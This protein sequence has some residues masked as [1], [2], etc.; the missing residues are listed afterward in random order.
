MSDR[1]DAPS[2][3][4]LRERVEFL[5]PS[6]ADA[7]GG[8]NTTSWLSSSPPMVRWAHVRDVGVRESFTDGQLKTMRTF[9][10]TIRFD[11]QV[12]TLVRV[13]FGSLDLQVRGVT[14][15][16]YRREWLILECDAE[17]QG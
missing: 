10:I 15:P 8:S 5:F 4:K 1:F 14:D 6:R 11:P 16:D 2:A 9:K 3:S 17:Y 13:R 7:G 12:T